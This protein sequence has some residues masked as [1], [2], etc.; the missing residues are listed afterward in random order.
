[1]NWSATGSINGNYRLELNVTETNV[2][3]ANNS[4]T[5]HWEVILRATGNYSFSAIGSTVVV[6][7]DG[8]VYNAYSQKSLNAHSAITIA[9]GDK[10]IE[11]D[12]NGSKTIYCSAS[13]TQTS[14]ASYTPGNMSCG[15]NLR[16]TDIARYANVSI[17]ERAKTINS[18]SINWNTDAARDHTQYSLNYAAWT[19]AN[20]TV[21]ADNRSGYFTIGNLNCNTI[22]SIKVRVKRADS[23]LWSESS[24]INIKTL[25][26]N[27]FE[28]TLNE[29]TLGNDYTFKFKQNAKAT[30]YIVIYDSNN[31]KL[32]SRN[33][34]A[35]TELNA[36]ITYTI[37]FTQ[38]EIDKI[39]KLF[40]SENYINLKL[41]LD[42]FDKQHYYDEYTKK[43]NLNGNIKTVKI[44]QND[45]IKRA[46]V[47]IK[48]DGMLK[49]CIIWVKNNGIMKRCL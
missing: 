45:V 38:E 43:C 33:T 17:T 26:K 35:S 41:Q 11:H 3:N 5:V 46:Q 28:G 27:K 7:V 40:D 48:K 1:M 37:K 2:N 44:K 25:D 22:Y 49:K 39:Y 10:N 30:T 6:N 42:T 14:G 23:Q 18:I 20:D 13:Y 31:N 9:S 21:S 36:V 47:Y 16:L 19:D 12:S 4:S 34:Y 29:I 8:E 32:L 15:G 24:E